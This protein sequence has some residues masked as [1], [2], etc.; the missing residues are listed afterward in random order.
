MFCWL[1]LEI[2]EWLRLSF[3]PGFESFDEAFAYQIIPTIAMTMLITTCKLRRIRTQELIRGWFPY[4][5][6]LEM[7][8]L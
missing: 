6:E 2:D 8:Q 5:Q 1:L 4:G 7:K 3:P